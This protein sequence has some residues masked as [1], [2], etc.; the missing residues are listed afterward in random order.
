MCKSFVHCL[1]LPF[2]CAVVAY[3]QQNPLPALSPR[4]EPTPDVSE[5]RIKL[6]VVV[7]DKSGKPVTGLNLNDFTLQDNNQPAKILSMRAVDGTIQKADPPVELILLIDAVNVGPV[8]VALFQNNLEK[9]LR[10]NGGHL[11][12]PVLLFALTDKGLDGLA[13][14]SVDGNS[15]AAKVA[16]LENR[17]RTINSSGGEWGINDRLNLSLMALRAIA[18]SEAKKPGR[19]LL[20]WIGPGWPTWDVR[21]YP[22]STQRQQDSF[23]WIVQ[24]ATRLREARISVYTPGTSLAYERFLQGVRTA[25]DANIA[26]LALGVLAVQSGGRVLNSATDRDLAAQIEHCIRDNSAFYTLSFDPP[27]ADHA[28]EYHDLMVKIDKPKLTVRTNSGYYNQT[29]EESS[30][31]ND[32]AS[33]ETGAAAQPVSVEQLEQV[34]NQLNGRSDAEAVRQLSGLA[35]TERLNSAKLSI[36]KVGL[37]G[38]KAQQALVALADA[39]AFLNPPPAEIPANA[40]PDLAAQRTMMAGTIDYL[41]KTLPEL[42]DFFATRLTVHYEEAPRKSGKAAKNTSGGGPL[43]LTGSTS[44]AV[45]YRDGHE[46]VDGATPKTKKANAN[47]EFLITKGTFGPILSVVIGDAS[48]GQLTWSHW[49]QGADG[50]LAV[51]HFAVPRDKSHYAPGYDSS[52]FK[53][54]SDKLQ[55]PTAYHGEIAIDQAAGTILRLV[56]EAD[57]EP[58]SPM[59]RA[60]IMVEYGPVEIGGKTYICPVRSVSISRGPSFLGFDSGGKPTLGPATTMLNDVSFGEYHMFRAESQVLSPGSPAP[61]EK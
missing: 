34:L 15:L 51:F 17:F 27:R 50:P 22:P 9:F 32:R 38:T 61:D 48:K 6:D 43:D 57:F 39:S 56:V 13:P 10:Q 5:G 28:N 47:A 18:Q 37:P 35:L 26:D 52:S 60:G 20:I 55:Q 41:G 8:G 19:K 4:P 16:H 42:P 54:E 36:W 1:A 21:E 3:A 14:P 44:A 40:P 46:V 11:A 58:G 31:A 29:V 25:D 33:S 7:A 12:Q 53:D 59:V 23:N 49:E 30:P 24:F 45:L 2:L